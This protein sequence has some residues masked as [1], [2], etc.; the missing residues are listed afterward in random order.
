MATVMTI[1]PV[2]RIEGHLSVKIEI[3]IVNGTQQVTNAW[4]TGTLFRG[5]EK[6]LTGRDPR[7]AQLI[8]QR[9]CGVCPI[10]HGLAAVNTLEDAYNVTVP[11][12]ARVMRNLV[13][14]ANF[15][16]SHILSFYHLSL[17]DYATCPNMLPWQPAWKGDM[18]VDA[19]KSTALVNNY[20]KALDINRKIQEMGA[21]FGGKTPHSPAY[22]P[23]GFTKVPTAADVTKAR[24]YLAEIVSF[25]EN[26]YIPDA[27]FL[28]TTYSDYYTIGAGC[29][30]LLAFGVFDLDQWG[31]TKLLGRGMVTGGSTSVM[32]VNTGAITEDV[33]NAWY[34]SPSGLNPAKGETVPLHP[35]AANAYSWIKAPRYAG[36][37][38]ET[39]PL[40][41][42]WVNGDYRRGISAM[43]R[44]LARAQEARK[45]ARALDGWLGEIREGQPSYLKATAATAG[46]GFGL[47]EAPRGALGHWLSIASSKIARYQVI[48]PTCWNASPRDAR[49]ILGPIEQA[50]VG[51]SVKNLK[52]P[53][54]V[55]RVIHSFDPCLS[56]AVHM[57]RPD[58]PEQVIVSVQSRT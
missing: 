1:D 50:L 9:I 52:E 17:P 41:R 58:E 42:M 12:N 34:S 13:L 55:M 16:Q 11:D 48:T 46:D 21:V 5:F 15:V 49:G 19:T 33:T 7:D 40:A 23:G 20:L 43:D 18:R 54:E 31:N 39:G 28:S 44:N 24:G 57:V 14:A 35:K 22:I 37:A 3:D 4:A 25:V 10:P 8:T 29:R 2:T 26:V 27:Q 47:T 30:N 36:A 38:C 45:I 6:L 32:P 56:C 53:V 51:T